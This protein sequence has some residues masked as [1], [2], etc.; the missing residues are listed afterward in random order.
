MMRIT[1]LTAREISRIVMEEPSNQGG[2]SGN[3]K[4]AGLEQ[5]ETESHQ[6]ANCTHLAINPVVVRSCCR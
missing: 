2:K 4:I 1:Y 6:G 5:W 3:G